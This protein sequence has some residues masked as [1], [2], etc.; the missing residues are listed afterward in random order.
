MTSLAVQVQSSIEVQDVAGELVV[1]SRLIA[2]RLGIEHRSLLRTIEKYLDRLQAKNQVRFEIHMVKLPQGGT[3]QQ[4]YAFLDERQA[5]L[6]MTLSRNTDQVLDCKEA[7]VDA[8]Q[9][10]K[11]I[12]RTVIPAQNDRIREIELELQL[13]KAK[14]E[15]LALKNS[16]VS[17]HGKELALR[18][19]G[20][21]EAIVEIKTVVTEVVEPATGRSVEILTADQLKRVVKERTGQN[22]KTLK[23]LTDKVREAGRDDLLVAVTRHNTNEYPIP[24]K[25]EEILSLVYR[26]RQKLIGE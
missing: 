12:I 20:D 23:W 13:Q 6:L 22:L 3:K 8:F 5:T 17:I 4:K 21:S 18:L 16:L 14:N 9:K 10:A 1:D 2:E 25:I 7:L 11:Q 15:G 19:M 26:D 24:E